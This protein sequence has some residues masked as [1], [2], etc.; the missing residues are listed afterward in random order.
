MS[1]AIVLYT[2]LSM[3]ADVSDLV[4]VII[5]EIE[6]EVD[7]RV[8]RLPDIVPTLLMYM[9]DATLASLLASCASARSLRCPAPKL[10]P[11]INDSLCTTVVAEPVAMWDFLQTGTVCMPQLLTAIAIHQNIFIVVLA[12]YLAGLVVFVLVGNL[13]EHRGVEFSNLGALLNNIGG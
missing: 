5:R 11:G 8:D 6:V 2:S 7:P 9:L 13:E 10:R 3:T 1:D 12:A 4:L